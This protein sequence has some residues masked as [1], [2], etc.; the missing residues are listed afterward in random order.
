MNKFWNTYLDTQVIDGKLQLILHAGDFICEEVINMNGPQTSNS[1]IRK[2]LV[3][4][5]EKMV[6]NIEFKK[7]SIIKN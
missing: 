4:K 5:F 1:E 3:D 7:S 6:N 2:N